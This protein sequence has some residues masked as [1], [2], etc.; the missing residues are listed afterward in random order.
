MLEAMASNGK[1]ADQDLRSTV[2]SSIAKGR[3][4]RINKRLG[5][6]GGTIA[7]VT[8]LEH[9]GMMTSAHHAA[10]LWFHCAGRASCTDLALCCS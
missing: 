6:F 9:A 2:S 7:V 4:E 8:P 10:G 3:I 1:Y 5:W